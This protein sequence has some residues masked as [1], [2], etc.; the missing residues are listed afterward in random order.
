MRTL[1]SKH[2]RNHVYIQADGCCEICGQP[3][4]DDWQID[5]II[6][7]S[8][9]KN[10]SI[11]NS[12]A[13]CRLCNLKK[14]TKMLRKHQRD[15]IDQLTDIAKEYKRTG[16][17][18]KSKLIGEVFPGGGK[19]TW[20]IIAGKIL[21][22]AGIVD[23]ICWVVPRK[24]LKNQGAQEFIKAPFKDLFPH[25][26]EIREVENINDVNPTR[27]SDG[28][29]TTYQA[30]VSARG[31][32]RNRDNSHQYEFKKNRYLLILDEFHHVCSDK[33]DKEGFNYYQA[34]KPLFEMASFTLCMSGTLFRNNNES[35]AFVDYSNGKPE[36]DIEYTYDDAIEDYAI[37]PI[38]FN[39]CPAISV[40]YT[41]NNTDYEKAKILNNDDLRVALATEYGM[42]L[43]EEGLR[44]WQA[45]RL[46]T[47]KR[48][49]LIIIGYDQA[50][51]RKIQAHLFRKNIHSC[52]AISDEKNASNT[53]KHFR[54]RPENIILT[55]CQMAYEG[56][57]CKEATHLIVLTRIRSLPWLIQMFTRVMRHD[58][59]KSQ[60]VPYELQYGFAFVP[61]DPAMKE[62]LDYIKAKPNIAVEDNT[63]SD[64]QAVLDQ[65]GS[66]DS[67]VPEPPVF[68]NMSS[69]M[70][71][72]YQSDTEGIVLTP[73]LTARIQLFQARHQI[74]QPATKTYQ[75]L[76]SM[77]Q[78]GELDEFR[79]TTDGIQTS[80]TIGLTMREREAELRNKIQKTASWLDNKFGEEYGHWNK[81]AYNAFRKGRKKMSEHELQECYDWMINQAKKE[82][83]NRLS[84]KHE[85]L[86]LET[87]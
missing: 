75:M 54:T 35:V 16:K 42:Q 37:I 10:T 61:D 31:N 56:L 66:D 58:S 69:E 85:L 7:Y 64:L 67:N 48:S 65:L 76:K 18:L 45:Y 30:L 52:L 39:N 77:G 72:L 83:Q 81:K 71:N 26:L 84:Q 46:E 27:G 12:Q 80:E 53:I 9:S 15:L 14:G 19:S 74:S 86:E 1:R 23:K 50:H 20:P 73:D 40:K 79:S 36:I 62:A 82:A 11:E 6:P 3:L 60:I 78:L 28:Y 24:S 8:F 49:K 29:V 51:C 87:V 2:D 25:D 5:H 47:N 63:L 4:G 68:E 57:D 38:Y 44:A 17:L 43:L 41:K 70:G 55:T 22:D 21:I 34:V 59:D 33:R 13:V 32:N